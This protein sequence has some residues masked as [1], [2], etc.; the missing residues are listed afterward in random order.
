M[1][2]GCQRDDRPQRRA[3]R[4]A[5]LATLVAAGC[6]S[7][8]LDPTLDGGSD[9]P[10]ATACTP[11]CPTGWV[12]QGGHC[13]P[14]GDPCIGVTCPADTRCTAGSCVQTNLC[15]DVVCPNPGEVCQDGECVAG[16]DDAD[17]DGYEAAADCDDRN[18][19]VH[20]GA[21]EACNGRDDDCDAATADGAADCPGLCCGAP[22]PACQDCCAGTDCGLGDWACTSFVCACSG[23]VCDGTCFAGATCCVASDCGTGEWVCEANHLCSCPGTITP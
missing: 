11:A 14:P 5:L 7:G 21:V 13:L 16:S 18:A 17:H 23:R 8:V 19:A 6:Q 1:A 3:A 4:A 15:E 9:E 12:C 22:T 10:D 20:P 2:P